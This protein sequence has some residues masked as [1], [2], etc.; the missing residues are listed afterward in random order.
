MATHHYDRLDHQKGNKHNSATMWKHQRVR[1]GSLAQLH[2]H[3]LHSSVGE[4][5]VSLEAEEW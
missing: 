3:A 2:S 5:G 4:L 1:S